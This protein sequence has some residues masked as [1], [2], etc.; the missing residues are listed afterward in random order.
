MR[1]ELSGLHYGSDDDTVPTV[2]PFLVVPKRRLLQGTRMLHNHWAKCVN[3]GWMLKTST[4]GH[5]LLNEHHQQK[6]GKPKLLMQ[7]I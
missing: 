1:K 6:N 4:L 7:C 5:E 2:N 3:V